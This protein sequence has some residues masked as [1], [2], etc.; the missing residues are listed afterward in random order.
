MPKPMTALQV[1]VPAAGVNRFGDLVCPACRVQHITP[2]GMLVVPGTGCC[3]LCRAAFRVPPRVARVANRR[4]AQADCRQAWSRV[5]SS[6][7][8]TPAGATAGGRFR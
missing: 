2:A 3:A 7:A 6:C 4:Q 8:A 5:G 1:L